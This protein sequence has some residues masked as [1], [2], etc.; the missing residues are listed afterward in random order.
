MS[1]VTRRRFIKLTALATGA[2]AALPLIGHAEKK[3]GH[4]K[5]TEHRARV[6][7][8][9]VEIT[10]RC[11]EANDIEGYAL[12]YAKDPHGNYLFT[13]ESRTVLE[14]EIVKGDIRLWDVHKRESWNG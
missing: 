4:V 2:V 3:Y 8:D 7:L 12:L 13:D 9:G 10:E 14:R 11:Y 5:G 1:D 6:S